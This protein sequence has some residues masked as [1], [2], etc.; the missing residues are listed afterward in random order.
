MN[1]NKSVSME[2]ENQKCIFYLNFL[3]LF[4]VTDFRKE[5]KTC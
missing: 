3:A 1:E 2:T 4:I 5:F